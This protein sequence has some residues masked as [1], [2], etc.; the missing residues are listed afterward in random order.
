MGFLF[1]WICIFNCTN[2]E[3]HYAWQPAF[4]RGRLR[5][6]LK[7]GRCLCQT[8]P[9]VN[10]WRLTSNISRR[11]DTPR[12]EKAFDSD[13]L[14][15]DFEKNIR[16]RWSTTVDLIVFYGRKQLIAFPI[17]PPSFPWFS[18]LFCS[19]HKLKPGCSSTTIYLT[20]DTCPN[21]N[22]AEVTLCRSLNAFCWSTCKYIE[23]HF[24]GSEQA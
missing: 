22:F 18:D 9:L 10:R 11:Q 15:G 21:F 14:R 12:P 20:S 7:H 4:F 17:R 6:W 19:Y 23:Q 8:V 5:P 13:S 3:P 1:T 2:Q 24:W 16:L